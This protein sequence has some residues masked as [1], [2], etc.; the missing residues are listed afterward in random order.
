[1]VDRF[2]RFRRS[3]W[4][5]LG[6]AVY[7]VLFD[8]TAPDGET[9]SEACDRYLLSRPTLTKVAVTVVARHLLN[10]IDERI[11]PIALLFGAV[12]SFR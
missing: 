10:D 8:F 3:D 6:L 2:K 5:W 9:L 4:G 12:K 1:M 7:V 11:D